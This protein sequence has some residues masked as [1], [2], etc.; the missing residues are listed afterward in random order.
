[1]SGR[2][3]RSRVLAGGY[4]T[5]GIVDQR[6]KKQFP[7][8]SLNGMTPLNIDYVINLKTLI[9]LGADSAGRF[10]ANQ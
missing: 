2:V 5:N 9:T 1:M 10:A 8:D 6:N 3:G 4:S 7:P